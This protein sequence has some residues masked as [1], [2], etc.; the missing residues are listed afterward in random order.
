MLLVLLGTVVVRSLKDESYQVGEIM[1][2]LSWK[3]AQ[4]G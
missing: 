4:A 1:T 3:V 2:F